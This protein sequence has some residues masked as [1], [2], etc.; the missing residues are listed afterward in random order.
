MKTRINELIGIKYPIIQG[1][2]AWAAFP[3]LVASVSNAGGLGNLG[4]GNM[5]PDQLR[6]N[7]KE[8]K[9]MTDK[10]FGVNFVPESPEIDRLL[11]VVAEEKVSVVTYGIG[12][13]HKII[14]RAKMDGF[15]AMPNVG[16]LKHAV[17]AEEDGADAVI[18]QGTEAGGHSSYIATM[19]LIPIVA[20]RIDIPIVAAGG[21]GDTRGL[22]AALALGADG[23]SMGTRFMATQECTVP[24]TIKEKILECGA[25][26]TVVTESVTG[27][28]CRVIHNKLAQEM[29][30]LGGKKERKDEID[31]GLGK[32]RQALVE[33]DSEFGSIPCGQ[34]CGMINDIPSCSELVDRI[35]NG[36]EQ[37][38]EATRA[39]IIS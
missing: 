36:A 30:S 13:P 6:E 38:L 2:M 20:D 26:G 25:G 15:I 34:I 28:R 35:V 9:D 5:T 33:G 12:D 14:G 29:L 32:M 39:K 1:A 8:I 24:S 31:I 16:S 17:I 11:D 3:P 7:I 18:I 10:P 4:S 22:V 27:V 21:I 19:V 37:I 23:I